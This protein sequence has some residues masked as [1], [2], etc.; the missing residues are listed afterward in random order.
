MKGEGVLVVLHEAWERTPAQ[1]V[2]LLVA[3][4]T[5]FARDGCFPGV[6]QVACLYR[7]LRGEVHSV[8][9][10]DLEAV[11]GAMGAFSWPAHVSS[12]DA[13]PLLEDLVFE[14]IRRE[15]CGLLSAED[16][17]ATLAVAL[18]SAHCA[19]RGHE[20]EELR[21]FV[22]VWRADALRRAARKA[23]EAAEAAAREAAV[24]RARIRLA[25]EVARSVITTVLAASLPVSAM[26]TFL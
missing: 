1:A 10:A 5:S 9:N 11:A 23:A 25:L 17:G 15:S 12:K 26:Q 6:N 13:V 14:T 7:T 18:H 21:D 19:G 4:A 20:A 3:M 2:R 22:D 24:H 8:G 16:C